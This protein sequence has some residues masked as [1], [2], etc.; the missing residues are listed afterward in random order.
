MLQEIFYWLI[1]SII[2][3]GFLRVGIILISGIGQRRKTRRIQQGIAEYLRQKTV[4]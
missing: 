1:A 3:A 4:A 2:A